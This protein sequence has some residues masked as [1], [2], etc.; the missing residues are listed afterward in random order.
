MIDEDFG[1]IHD[2]PDTK[3]KFRVVKDTLFYFGMMLAVS[4]EFLYLMVR[5]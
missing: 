4:L 2:V 1:M 5:K 3:P